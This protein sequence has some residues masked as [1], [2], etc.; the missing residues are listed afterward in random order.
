MHAALAAALLSVLAPGTPQTLPEDPLQAHAYRVVVLKH[1]PDALAWKVRL[2]SDVLLS[3]QTID[4]RCKRTTYCPR[5]S[6]RTCAD[7]SRVRRGVCAAPRCVPMHSLVWVQGSGLL[8]VTDRGGAVQSAPSRYLRRG[9]RLVLDEWLPRCVGD[10]WTG[11]GTRRFVPYA[12]VRRG[13]S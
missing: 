3:G 10:C 12:I 9:E 11:P 1:P 6:G 5:C 7:G 8:C 2:Y 4:G 13:E